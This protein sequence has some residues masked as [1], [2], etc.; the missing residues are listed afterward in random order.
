M[1]TREP[2]CDQGTLRQAPIWDLC[3]WI[4]GRLTYTMKSKGCL[5]VAVIATSAT[6]PMYAGAGVPSVSNLLVTDVTPRS[7]SVVWSANEPSRSGLDVYY[8]D[9]GY[10]APTGAVVTPQ[11]VQNG[12]AVIATL[13][14][15]NGVMKVQVTGLL[16]GTTYYFQTRTTSKST[17]DLILY[18]AEA[19]LLAVTTEVK[20]V[21]SKTSGSALVP[22]SNDVVTAECYLA[23]GVTPA[24]GTLVFATVEGAKNPVSAFVGD[25]IAPPYALIDLNN[26]YG[27]GTGESLDIGRG[28]NLTLVNFRGRLGNSAI[29]HRVP[30][31]AGLAEIK[32]PDPG[33]APGWN[34]LSL[35]LEPQNPSLATV[36][37]PVWSKLASVWAY[38]TGLDKW[39]RYDRLG[40]PFLNDLNE[41]HSLK[42]YW[43]VMN[44]D[45]SLM[46]EGSFPAAS[47]PIHAGWNL[48]G[49]R[50]VAT[51]ATTDAVQP[52]ASV[53]D[54]LWT[55]ETALDKWQRYCPS[56]PPFL[57]DLNWIK[58]GKAYW[59][60]ATGEGIW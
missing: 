34:L 52:I 13:A 40:P 3:R 30:A 12:S 19:P 49:Y 44:N 14:E 25:G 28:G 56:G 41:M 35:P 29:V 59:V 4:V 39:F 6:A 37:A 38:D 32:P 2:L 7:F 47:I 21:R 58:P 22:F 46:V 55:Y 18:P 31:D 20:T 42:G 53:L 17:A 43:I 15:D 11:P 51:Q 24:Q 36:L 16:P 48:A 45:A 57:N 27:R 5:L 50:S 9:K 8:D 60:D 54:C 33:L 1:L 10:V 23:D 26:L